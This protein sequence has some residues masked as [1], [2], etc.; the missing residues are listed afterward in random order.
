MTDATLGASGLWLGTRTG[1]GGIATLPKSFYGRSLWLHGQLGWTTRIRVRIGIIEFG[2]AP[3]DSISHR[4]GL[5]FMSRLS[6]SSVFT[7]E[8]LRRPV[9]RSTVWETSLDMILGDSR[10]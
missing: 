4:V 6:R 3:Q 9:R 8:R 7:A 10:S 2:I 1:A 5:K